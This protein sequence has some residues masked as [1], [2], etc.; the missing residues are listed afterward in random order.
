[1]TE[2][3]IRGRSYNAIPVAPFDEVYQHSLVKPLNLEPSTLE[4]LRPAS[5][6]IGETQKTTALRA[7]SRW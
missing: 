1:M 7:G 6:D 3:S 2:I 5:L 4:W